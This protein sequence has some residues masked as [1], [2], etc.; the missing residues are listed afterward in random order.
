[1]ANC[2]Y[3]IGNNSPITL[4][5]LLAQLSDLD[6]S[7]YSD[8]VYSRYPRRDAMREKIIKVNKEYSYN[9]RKD[10][11]ASAISA[12]IDGEPHI[13]DSKVLS[14]SEFIDHPSAVID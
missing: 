11:T 6:V 13:G 8:V 10:T 9:K 5:E 3:I 12:I 4:A 1:M 7:S 2:K 14:I